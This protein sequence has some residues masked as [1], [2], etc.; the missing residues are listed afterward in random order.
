[1]QPSFFGKHR[2]RT[3]HFGVSAMKQRTLWIFL[4]TLLVSFASH[5]DETEDA[6][7][8]LRKKIFVV[9]TD[10]QSSVDSLNRVSGSYDRGFAPLNATYQSASHQ[11]SGPLGDSDD[12]GSSVGPGFSY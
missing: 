7:E 9:E 11:R 8:H 1:M 4:A 5:A 10:E 6:K 12:R 2:K 3:A